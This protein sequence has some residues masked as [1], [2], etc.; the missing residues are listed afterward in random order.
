MPDRPILPA[1]APLDTGAMAAAQERWASRAK[2]PGSL[3]QLEDL[4]V[5]LAGITGTC[6]PPVITRPAI[7]VFAGDHGVVADGASAWPSDI[8]GL[9][10]RAMAGEVAAINTFAATVGADVH[11]VDVGVASDL[12]GLPNVRHRKVR[13]GT[14]SLAHGP[15]M[16]VGE[17]GA[18]LA[19]GLDVAAELIAGGAD[20]LVAGDMGI[21]NTTPSAA[22]IGRFAGAMADTVTGTGAGLP[23]DR[24]DAKTAI[25][26][27]AIER[28]G[29]IDDPLAVLAEIGGLEIAAMAG[30][31]L[32]AAAAAVPFIVDGVIAAAAALTADALV[33]GT[34]ARAVAGHQSTEPAAAVALKHLGLEPL[35][36]LRL[37][38]GE[39]TGACL[40]IP[41]LQ[42]SARALRDM[43]DLPEG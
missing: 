3:G 6:P 35:L 42:A 8:T 16:S 4:A 17:A 33:P 19:V 15:A 29:Q 22:L 43:A 34:A 10:V 13:A 38:L 12:G 18:A 27:D 21:G 41:L 7:A 20:C 2:P 37:R 9:M 39:G 40:A 28:A 1:I 31:Y 32:G 23:A 36:D 24:L 25:V 5:Q 30:L 26:A 14:A 11:L